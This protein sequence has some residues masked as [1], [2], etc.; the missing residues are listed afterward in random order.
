M[1]LFIKVFFWV[2]LL[3]CVLRL[4]LISS[5]KYPHQT[6]ETVGSD[7]VKFIEKAIFVVWAAILLWGAR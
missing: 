3:G 4:I 7:L 5:R 6:T 1:E 2:G